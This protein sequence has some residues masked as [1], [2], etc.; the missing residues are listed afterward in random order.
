MRLILSVLLVCFVAI[1]SVNA[2]LLKPVKLSENINL[3][4]YSVT[5]PLLSPDGNT[6]YFAVLNHPQNRF[7][8]K[9]S[10]DIWYSI[11]DSEGNWGEGKRLSNQI[12]LGRY[13]AIHH[14][15]P[16]GKTF[17][18]NGVFSSAGVWY[19]R[20][21]SRITQFDEHSWSKPYV[22]KIPQLDS[23]SDGRNMNATFDEKANLMVVSFGKKVGRSKNKLYFSQKKGNGSW[24]K[25]KM[26]KDLRTK[27]EE[28]A[29][30]L[31]K[32][33]S[34]VFAS[35][36]NQVKDNADFYIATPT[37]DKKGRLF[38]WWNEEPYYDSVFNNPHYDAFI[39]FTENEEMAYFSSVEEKKG[40][41]AIYQ[42]KMYEQFPYVT[43]SGQLMDKFKNAP[44][45]EGK[46]V[47]LVFSEK[48]SSNSITSQI[49]QL[50]DTKIVKDVSAFSSTYVPDSIVF[51]ENRFV[52]FR[53]PFNKEVEVSLLVENHISEVINLSTVGLVEHKE[54]Q[55]N[56][57]VEPL[58][59]AKLS[60]R[61]IDKGTGTD[62]EQ[63]IPLSVN[64]QQ[65]N[66]VVKEGKL[67]T[68]KLSLGQT[69]EV[70]PII[71]GYDIFGTSVS[72]DTLDSYA[73]LTCEVF[74][75]KKPELKA[76]YRP[77]VLSAKDSSVVEDYKLYFNDKRVSSFETDD[78][79]RQKVKLK[80]DSNYVIDVKADNFIGLSDSLS[81]TKADNNTVFASTFYLTPV[82]VGSVVR[83]DHVYFEFG[84][85]TLKSTSYPSLDKVI[86][87][88]EQNG[89]VK[90]EIGGH[91]DN[92]GS[93]KF[94]KN[95]SGLR[96]NSVKEYLLSKGITPNRIGSKGYGF[97]KPVAT[98][99]TEE[100]QA[101]NRRV[102]FTITEK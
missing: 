91:T 70:G 37:Y 16:D 35:T 22:L 48:G 97:D 42:V 23:K 8:E 78:N 101:L 20:G 61:V 52:S 69:Y 14:I 79:G 82:E 38:G 4:G 60:C 54:V 9:N 13:N 74:A 81:I 34:L 39:T 71:T 100:G 24:T 59:Y 26:I 56:F 90:I 98:N 3:S 44:I 15:L 21:F 89:S 2:Q 94:N 92:V 40:L 10:Q 17:I 68:M 25:L 99:E 7:G 51:G 57:Y 1:I 29:P 83:L 87:F 28:F 49:G 19:K 46:E 73:E 12:N 96:A 93:A 5:H 27:G 30:R 75:K 102:E 55:Q 80:L 58:D 6:L 53:L 41:S 33:S 84:K 66:A 95:L 43:Y 50:D 31:R 88:M 62:F 85:A 65:Y 67:Y 72:L 63:Q 47:R 77:I 36:F 45:G 18:I 32:D 11:K 76:Y 86:E 64:G